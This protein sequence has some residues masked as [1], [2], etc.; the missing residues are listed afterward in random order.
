MVLGAGLYFVGTKADYC[1]EKID[2]IQE[3]VEGL[4]SEITKKLDTTNEEL[5]EIS[6]LCGEINGIREEL[7]RG[8][9]ELRNK[10]PL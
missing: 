7:E 8:V 9:E 4:A 1:I 3:N 10:F 2:S 6:E 5:S